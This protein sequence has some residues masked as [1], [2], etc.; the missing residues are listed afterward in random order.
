M[1]VLVLISIWGVG[2]FF[3]Q[4]FDCTPIAA[5]W[6]KSAGG[7]YGNVKCFDPLPMFYSVAASDLIIDCIILILPQ[8][9]LW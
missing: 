7:R 8:P 4:L 1:I 6:D 9:L 2:C 5:N 3:A